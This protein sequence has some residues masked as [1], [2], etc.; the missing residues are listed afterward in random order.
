[1]VCG[2]HVGGT[3]VVAMSSA[4]L[5]RPLEAYTETLGHLG[6][7]L[8]EVICSKKDVLEHVH[9]WAVPFVNAIDKKDPRSFRAL[10]LAEARFSRPAREEFWDMVIFHIVAAGSATDNSIFGMLDSNGI[11]CIPLCFALL[12]HA[13]RDTGPASPCRHI[14][15][16]RFFRAVWS[17]ACISKDSDCDI[18]QDKANAG[19]RCLPEI[20]VRTGIF[21][22]PYDMGLNEDDAHVLKCQSHEVRN[23]MS[24][25]T[26]MAIEDGTDHAVFLS[27]IM[28]SP[29]IATSD[30]LELIEDSEGYWD[31]M[32]AKHLGM[33]RL[34]Y[35]MHS[36]NPCLLW[37]IELLLD[38]DISSSV[39]FFGSEHTRIFPQTAWQFLAASVAS[40]PPFTFCKRSSLLKAIRAS[41]KTGGQRFRLLCRLGAA[42]GL[43]TPCT[44]QWYPRGYHDSVILL[45]CC[46]SSFMRRFNLVSSPSV[47]IQLL[48][49]YIQ[50]P[51]MLLPGCPDLRR[52][53]GRY[54][55]RSLA[56]P[57]AFKN[58]PSSFLDNASISMFNPYRELDFY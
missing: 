6:T 30:F 31:E 52:E 48:S 26:D 25:L 56:F 5:S 15:L 37:V 23:G 3:F 34:A 19:F 32:R 44:K 17:P 45:C 14:R 35:P 38:F 43:Y 8:S 40:A 10:L 4:C 51:L 36:N 22:S 28:L 21:L 12:E 55:S 27:A 9:E 16:A 49:C 50:H 39:L 42:S 13:G 7:N 54:Y 46:I 11:T 57:F 58:M 2:L 18:T 1:M 29:H 24:V 20:F 41:A 47:I 53:V 33:Q